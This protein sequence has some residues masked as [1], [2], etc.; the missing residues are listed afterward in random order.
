MAKGHAETATGAVRSGGKGDG[1]VN[2]RDNAPTEA[3]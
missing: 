2:L 1:C 3:G